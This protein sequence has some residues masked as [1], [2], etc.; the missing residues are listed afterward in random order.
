MKLHTV[1]SALPML[2]KRHLQQ[3]LASPLH[4]S[5]DDIRRLAAYLYSE[6]KTTV[7]LP[8]AV[9]FAAV[10][11]ETVPYDD[12][13][14]RRVQSGLLKAIESFLVFQRVSSDAPKAQFL[15]AQQ[16]HELKLEKPFQQ[17]LQELQSTLQ[18]A[19]LQDAA[20]LQQQCE[21]EKLAFE[22]A[23]Q[24]DRSAETTLQTILLAQEKAFIADKLRTVCTA[25][26]YQN[27]YKLSYDFGLLAAVLERVETQKWE[28]TQPA[29]ALYYFIYKMNTTDEGTTFFVGLR[30]K[31]VAFSR[32]FS[33]NELRNIYFFAVNYAVKQCKL[34]HLH[35]FDV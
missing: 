18:N 28:E 15:L 1:W 31:M 13:A 20:A 8:K 33:S 30:Q 35:N 14:L 4:N 21:A 6:D 7:L 19:D 16:Y 25:M 22:H 10:F 26:S 5:R 12:A 17:S 3:W 34:G 24:K 23:A 9:I 27:L 32:H 2:T 11:G 29:I